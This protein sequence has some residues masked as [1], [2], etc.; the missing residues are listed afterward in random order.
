MQFAEHCG[1]APRRPERL[2]VVLAGL[3]LILA[4]LL[5]IA[6]LAL[7][8]EFGRHSPREFYYAW[9]LFLAVLGLALA[10]RPGWAAV[11]LAL[12]FVDLGLGTASR[13]LERS[14][15]AVASVMPPYYH[16]RDDFRWHP[17]LQAVPIPSHQ[18]GI[19]HHVA[20]N[21][22][23][24]TRGR[25]PTPAELRDKRVIAVF[26]GST[27]YDLAVSDGE[28]WPDQLERRLGP[29]GFVVLNH[30]V[31]GYSTGEHVIQSAFYADAFGRRPDCAVYY[32]G[33]NDLHNA[34]IPGLDPGFA[35]FHLPNQVDAL[36]TRRISSNVYTP[37]PLLTLALRLL[38]AAVDT[39]RPAP[40]PVRPPLEVP[41]PALEALFLR[42]VETISALNRARG[43]VTIWIGQVLNRARLTGDGIDGWTPVIRLRD[44]WPMQERL[45]DLL[46]DAADRL[47][48]RFVQ[49]P[50]DAFS[51]RDFVDLGHFSPSGSA[52]L[53]RLVAP[54]IAAACGAP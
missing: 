33:W 1:L 7:A 15:V 39:T 13:V 45:N 27:T 51:D 42:N 29:D 18:G 17:L 26:G 37:S 50:A 19:A 23:A 3:L 40:L 44:L 47:G 52:L 22:S 53:A 6:G 9:L 10:R 41:D 46:R 48:D 11:P 2:L 4:L 34:G 36:R 35:D 14:G 31:P 30:G 38:S 12:G 24:G 43:I 16:T 28:T 20:H 32:V 25:E 54:A 8:G 49:P 21:T 5:T